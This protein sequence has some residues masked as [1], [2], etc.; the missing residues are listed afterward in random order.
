MTDLRNEIAAILNTTEAN[1]DARLIGLKIAPVCGRC[2]GS[3]SYSFNLTDGSRCYGCNGKG[4]VAPK[5]RDMGDML[6]AAEAAVADGRLAAYVQFLSSLKITKAATDK[7]MSAWTATGISKA[8]KWMNAAEFSRSGNPEF[9]RDAD[10]SAINRKMSDAYTVVQNASYKLNAKSPTYR[11]D[12]IALAALVEQ[13][14]ADVAAAD[15]EFKAY[16]A[17]E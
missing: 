11:E 2:S 13:A 5:T 17:G 7:I 4:H 14:L 16:V 3:G 9:K 15:A 10:I 8:Y 6:I 12:V 1:L